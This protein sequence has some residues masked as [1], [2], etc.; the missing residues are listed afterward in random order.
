M[1]LNY[2]VSGFLGFGLS[3]SLFSLVASQDVTGT[4]E[5]VSPEAGCMQPSTSMDTLNLLVFSK[6]AGYRHDSIPAGIAALEALAE[7]RIWRVTA[8]EDAAEFNDEASVVWDVVIFLNTTGDILDPDQEAAFERFIQGGG[9]FVGIH[10]AADTEYDWAWY[11]ELVGAYF[12]SHP[13]ITDAQVIVED[14]A[15]PAAQT[16][17]ES[18]TR[19]DEWYNFQTN[20]RDTVHVILTVD[21][22]SYEG[23]T[24][25]DDH[26]IAWSHEYDGGRAFYTAMGHTVESFS[27]PLYLEHLI[28]G[29]E[30]AGGRCVSL[31]E[32]AVTSEPDSESGAG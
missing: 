23:G 3:L 22:T 7:D 27:E 14:P 21:E 1:R 29:I 31:P 30:W 12:A 32:A 17:P 24:M 20:P 16:L 13:A 4:P 26:P 25:P 9:G 2:L 8:T 5:S 10:S 6:T 19:T 15:A 18:W 11:G 28:G